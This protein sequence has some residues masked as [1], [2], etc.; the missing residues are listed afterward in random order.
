MKIY[1]TV[2]IIVIIKEKLWARD[3]KNSMEEYINGKVVCQSMHVNL[4]IRHAYWNIKSNSD[5][6]P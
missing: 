5:S 6:V 2:P 3:N 1:Y 4:A